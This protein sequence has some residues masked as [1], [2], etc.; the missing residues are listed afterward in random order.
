MNDDP[1]E[2]NIKGLNKLISMLKNDAFV[3]VGILGDKDSRDEGSNASIGA[4]H[5]F[6]DPTHNLPIRSFL[7]MPITEKIES[8][9][10]AAGGFDEQTLKR[11]MKVGSPEEFLNKIGAIAVSC[12][13][14]AFDSG[15]FGKWPPWSNPNYKNNTGMLL[16]NTQQLRNS[17]TWEVV[18]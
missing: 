8:E 5:E 16:V 18:T 17:I 4:R 1:V 15:G 6:G 12:V 10:K 2:L 11:V 14:D 13:Q 3:K 9:L 7:R